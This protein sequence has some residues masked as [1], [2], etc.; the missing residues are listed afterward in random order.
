MSE[1]KRSRWERFVELMT[2]PSPY[3]SLEA[4]IAVR[5]VP[6]PVRYADENL[7]Y[8]WRLACVVAPG[9]V[10][11]IPYL[12]F[13]RKW[14]PPDHEPGDVIETLKVFRLWGS[15]I[16]RRPQSTNTFTRFVGRKQSD[17]RTH[18]PWFEV[19]VGKSLA[20]HLQ[21]LLGML[22]ATRDDHVVL[23]LHES[24]VVLLRLGK[25]GIEAG[26]AIEIPRGT[27]I[28]PEDGSDSYRGLSRTTLLQRWAVSCEQ[29]A[30]GVP[31]S[32]SRFLEA[33]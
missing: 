24:Q 6:Y 3:A 30:R 17:E 1:G 28:E 10:L 25:T 22:E 19:A 21:W 12:D 23:D 29:S 20:G 16:E 26:L 31:P 4:A 32:L 9:Q 11:T 33:T 7:D 27:R 13:P 18:C 5:K 8:R 15:H 2:R 14:E